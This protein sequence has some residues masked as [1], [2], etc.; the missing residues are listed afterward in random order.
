MSSNTLMPVQTLLNEAIQ[1]STRYV[2]P[3]GMSSVEIAPQKKSSTN[4]ITRADIAY[5][6]EQMV[7]AFGH[8]FLSNYGSEDTGAWFAALKE[9]TLEDLVYGFQQLLHKW[10][11]QEWQ[12]GSAW[13]PNAKEFHA[14][15]LRN[16]VDYGLPDVHKAFVE[17]T[18]HASN[19]KHSWSHPVI[20]H[21]VVKLDCS[22]RQMENKH[23]VFTQFKA[24]YDSLCRRVMQGDVLP[25]IPHKELKALLLK[26]QPSS[27]HIALTHLN[28]MREHLGLSQSTI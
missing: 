8:K 14:L 23:I 25:P 24:I 22:L 4:T 3:T 6:W 2:K 20:A 18:H 11:P 7:G 13:P 16:L 9:F 28:K 1:P 26:R 17:A 12:Q 5:L 10:T 21:A 27:K 19:H 15:C